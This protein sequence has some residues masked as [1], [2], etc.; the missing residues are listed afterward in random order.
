M[1]SSSHPWKGLV[2]GALGGAAGTLAMN[3]FMKKATKWTDNP[4]QSKQE[5]SADEAAAFSIAGKKFEEGESSTETV[6]RLAY[7][8]VAGEEP[9]TEETRQT[10]SQEVHWA[11][12]IAMGALYGGVRGRGPLPDTLG[13]ALFGSSVWLL[14]SELALPLLGLS[15]GPAATS[16]RK[17]AQHFAAHLVYGTVTA[18][19][20]Q[21]LH[22]LTAP[23]LRTR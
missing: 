13:G 12:G 2:L 23:A 18:A 4:Q 11:F 7:R 8:A 19:T 22:R 21:G 15:P 3:A 10:L 6:G 17:H 9:R 14:A 20:T 1:H 5:E 16:G